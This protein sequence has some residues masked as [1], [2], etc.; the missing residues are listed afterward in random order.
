VSTTEAQLH[1]IFSSIQGEGLYIGERQ[2]FI[3]F[4]MCN[5]SC[6]YCDS[7]ESLVPQKTFRMEE[8]P[9][10]KDFKFY[11]NPATVDQLSGFIDQFNKQKSLHHS[12]SITGGEPLLQVDFLKNLIPKIRAK[13]LKI[14]LETNGTM[15]ERLSEIIDIIDIV[16]MDIKLPSMTGSS[17]RLQEHKK[18]LHAAKAKELFVK[19]VFGKQSKPLEIENTSKAIAEINR[20]IPL[21]LQ[22]VTPVREI[23]HG[24]T[25]EQMISFHAI[26]KRHLSNVRVIPQVHK[27]LGQL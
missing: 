24:P 26:A 21:V 13:E 2:I 15:P 8:T 1:E 17:D 19:I 7:P 9:G 20:E 18:A 4:L 11:N 3:R 25:P 10:K 23:K 6:Q 27:M 5:M 16:A 14:Y 22:P 12:I